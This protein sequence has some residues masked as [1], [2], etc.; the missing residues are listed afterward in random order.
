[1]IEMRCSCK[2]HF[3]SFYG[4]ANDFIGLVLGIACCLTVD[5]HVEFVGVAVVVILLVQ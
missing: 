3:V 2:P 4:F 5:L 1:M